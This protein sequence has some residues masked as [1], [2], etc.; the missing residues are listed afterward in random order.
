MTPTTR[1]LLASTLGETR[2]TTERQPNAGDSEMTSRCLQRDKSNSASRQLHNTS[3]DT[4]KEAFQ[5]IGITM[6]AI[7][8]VYEHSNY[9]GRALQLQGAGDYDYPTLASLTSMI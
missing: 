5:F 8:T 3:L 2:P 9:S 1:K 4:L 7:A 6:P